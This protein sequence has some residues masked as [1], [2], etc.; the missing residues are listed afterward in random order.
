MSNQNSVVMSSLSARQI[1]SSLIIIG[2]LFFVFGFISWANA[3]LIPYF[4]IACELTH[5]ESYLV[6]F[7]FY[8][9]YLVM[10][11]PSSY[12]LKRTGF[13]KGIMIGFWIMAAGTFFFIPAAFIRA[14]NLF[15]SGLFI[16]GVGLSILQSAANPYVTILGPLQSAAKR[17][18]IMGIFNKGA[19]IMAP[20]LL[21]AFILKPNDDSLVN[22][23]H[24]VSETEKDMIL[25]NLI[26]RVIIP[27]AI[28]T[29][30]LFILGLIVRYSSLPEI[31]TETEEGDVFIANA[32]KK[33]I[34]DFP[35]L[36]L[37]ALAIFLHVGTQVIAVDTII[38]YAN[39][40]GISLSS[41]KVFPSLTLLATI[42]GYLTG[43]F[44]I[45]KVISQKTALQFC[46]IL[47]LVLSLLT[48]YT[49]GGKI[50]IFGFNAHISTWFLVMLGFANSLIWAGIWPLALNNLGRFTKLGASV[51]IMGLCGNAILPLLYGLVADKYSVRDGY[52]I[53]VPCYLY[54]IFY[55]FKGYSIKSWNFKTDDE[56]NN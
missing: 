31:E 53:L 45:P 52:M 25:N 17:I 7:S 39:Y 11:V 32:N 21:A 40:Q 24:L 36:I 27:Y 5:F 20:L 19:G 49:G 1:N 18:S 47:G 55:A 48:V 51:L 26:K 3:I 22:S 50:E 35:Y 15:L 54:L 46:T 4:K 29:L 23:L 2:T 28:I 14:Y 44:L 33:T 41:A 56:T 13:K 38:G 9:A 42:I 30:I 43:I 12:L 37:G 34:F 6:A 10:S 8:I 16:I